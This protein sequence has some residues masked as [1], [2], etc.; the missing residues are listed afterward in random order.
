MKT[1]RQKTLVERIDKL[2]QE[3]RMLK[4]KLG[5]LRHEKQSISKELK[6]AR[7][8][9][10]EIPGAVILVQDKQILFSNETAGRQLGYSEQEIMGCDLSNLV[11][12]RSIKLSEK[13][14]HNWDLGRPVPDRF[15]IFM[16]KKDG[17]ALCC[18]V[19][20]KKIRFHGRGA[21]LINALDL[22]QRKREEKKMRQ[23]RKIRAL[24][25]MVSGLS[26]DFNR[27]LEIFK[28]PGRKFQDVRSIT[29]KEVVRSLRRLDAVLEIGSA[30]SHRINCLT[31]PKYIDS[32]VVLFDPKDV[33]R[34]AVS[35]TQPKWQEQ[36]ADHITV[37]IYLRTLSPILG[38]PGEMRDALVMMIFNAVDAM[39]DGGEIYLTLEENVGYAWIYIQDNG[40][41]IPDEIKEKIFDP[42]FTITD[43]V[44]LG[45]GL[46]LANAIIGR[47][48]GEIEVLSQTGRGTTFIV[49]IPFADRTVASVDKRA[50]NNIRES[51]ILIVS[52]GNIATDLLTQMFK[53]KGGKVTFA[54]SCV[55][56]L[57]L[58][59]KKKFDLVVADL[60][61]PDFKI[62]G[63]IRKIR[64]M[65]QCLPIAILDVG[66]NGKSSSGSGRPDA[67]LVIESPLEMVG[68][69]LRISEA[70]EKKRRKV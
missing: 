23:A 64:E 4:E 63:I 8:L 51:Q 32:E 54:Y 44:R 38:H 13:I 70:L 66:G 40:M 1:V 19:N 28:D 9:L 43:G 14:Y 33:I 3:N 59:R 34:E 7:K 30:I 29:N 16:R 5:V 61:T 36:G 20:W 37:N 50:K 24:A 15:E 52:D 65:K 2:K 26:R 11:H 46:S 22:E 18:A 42:F 69:A 56:G 57:K 21:Y 10:N 12:P 35:I 47:H 17:E 6:D 31:R 48:G 68:V 58:L 67:D 53:A 49:K 62:A 55:E 60:D 25:R 27:G 45:L 41:G 39:P